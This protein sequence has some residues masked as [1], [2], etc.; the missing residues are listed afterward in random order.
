MKPMNRSLKT[1]ACALVLLTFAGT[2]SGAGV[3]AA[4]EA[5]MLKDRASFGS[6]M[7]TDGMNAFLKTSS[8]HGPGTCHFPIISLPAYYVCVMACKIS[9]G[10]DACPGTCER[11]LT[12]CT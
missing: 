9:G 5:G 6:I 4:E 3:V 2:V 7:K 12:V 10:G 8:S 11:A 1:L